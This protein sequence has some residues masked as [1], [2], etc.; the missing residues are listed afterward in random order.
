MAAASTSPRVTRRARPIRWITPIPARL[1][2]RTC[3]AARIPAHPLA[4]TSPTTPRPSSP[5]RPRA[6]A[7]TTSTIPLVPVPANGSY[8]AGQTLGFTVNTDESVTVDTSGGTPRLALTLG[9]STVY[10]NYA[11]VSGTSALVFTYTVQP[12]DTDSD[13]IA[14]GALQGNGGTLKDTAGNNMNLTLNSVGATASVLVDTT[15]PTVSSV[16]VPS[17][18]TYYSNQNLDFTS[19]FSEAITSEKLAVKSRF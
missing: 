15:A 2:R 6:A 1:R 5:A 17:N 11:S 18:G 16:S 19:N 3:R 14:V 13:G 7:P 8:K 9:S 10:A 12:G 4:T